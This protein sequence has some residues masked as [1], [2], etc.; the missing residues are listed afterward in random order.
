MRVLRRVKE[1]CQK[2]ERRRG[3]PDLQGKKRGTT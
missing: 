1:G 2:N 3:L